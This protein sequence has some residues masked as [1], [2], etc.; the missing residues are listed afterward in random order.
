MATAVDP[1]SNLNPK[2]KPLK[3]VQKIVSDRLFPQVWSPSLGPEERYR[4]FRDYLG[5]QIQNEAE[6]PIV[7]VGIGGSEQNPVLEFLSTMPKKADVARLLGKLGLPEVLF[8]VTECSLPGASARPAKGGDEIG[9]PA[10]DVGTLG[11]LVEDQS[12][13]KFILSC[14]HVIAALNSGK[15]CIDETWEPGRSRNRIGF[16]H[17]FKGITF[18]GHIGNVIDAAISKP[19]P[20]TDVEKGIRTLG[21]INGLLDP[22][23][24]ET[25]VRK[26][27][28]ESKVTDGFVCIRDL[29]V[30]IRFSNKQ[31]ALFE[32]QL[33]VTGTQNVGRFA[34]NGD[35]GAVIVDGENN[36][37]GLLFAVDGAI[38]LTYVNPISKVLG[39][40]GVK[41][42]QG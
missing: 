38:D 39:Y 6:V 4:F 30:L 35:S 10:G 24:L 20:A 5:V 23:P 41:L 7:G 17:D 42:C 12:G 18:G 40:F 11:C 31:K 3:D 22:V 36:V 14:N 8:R 13:Q 25:K 16:L 33:C 2:P 29:S 15:R 21:A 9:H 19:N 1:F 27:G 34:K 37:A 26:S 28:K 32:K